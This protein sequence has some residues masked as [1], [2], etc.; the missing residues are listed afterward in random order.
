VGWRPLS[1]RVLSLLSDAETLGQDGLELLGVS[2]VREKRGQHTRA[3][4]LYERSIASLLPTEIDR[5]AR[6]LCSARIPYAH[7]KLQLSRATLT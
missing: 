4:N 2:R 7:K 3:R 6:R 5:V 1:S